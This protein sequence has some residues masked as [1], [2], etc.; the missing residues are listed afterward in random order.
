MTVLSL[1]IRSCTKIYSEIYYKYGLC[2]KLK[3]LE[4]KD[5]VGLFTENSASYYE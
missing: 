4:V 5:H 3:P 2:V 1:Y